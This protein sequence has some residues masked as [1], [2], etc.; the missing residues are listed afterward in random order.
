MGQ[1]YNKITKS[2]KIIR[3]G[4]ICPVCKKEKQIGLLMCWPCWR[5]YK[6]SSYQIKLFEKKLSTFGDRQGE[7]KVL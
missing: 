3:A 6:Q 2:E 1:F 5:D 4:V 7:S